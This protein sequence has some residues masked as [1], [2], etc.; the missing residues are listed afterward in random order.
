[1]HLFRGGQ[2]QGVHSARS[3]SLTMLGNVEHGLVMLR[4][5]SSTS[6]VH[7]VPQWPETAW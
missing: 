3:H 4:G 2:H 6:A 7:S 5:E 1:M